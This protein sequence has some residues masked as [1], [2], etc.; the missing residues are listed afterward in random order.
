MLEL[1]LGAG[2]KGLRTL[3]TGRS[4]W[5]RR[6]PVKIGPSKAAKS[7][8]HIEMLKHNVDPTSFGDREGGVVMPLSVVHL[9]MLMGGA[10]SAPYWQGVAEASNPIYGYGSALTPYDHMP[11]IPDEFEVQGGSLPRRELKNLVNS[12]PTAM[13]QGSLNVGLIALLQKHGGNP[14]VILAADVAGAVGGLWCNLLSRTVSFGSFTTLGATTGLVHLYEDVPDEIVPR[15]LL[16]PGGGKL[17]DKELLERIEII[18]GAGELAKYAALGALDSTQKFIDAYAL[19]VPLYDLSGITPAKV[20]FKPKALESGVQV[21]DDRIVETILHVA[22]TR[23][24]VVL[25]KEAV[26]ES[27]DK[28][29][30]VVTKDGSASEAADTSAKLGDA[31]QTAAIQTFQE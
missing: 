2:H 31:L 4:T 29:K 11:R 30:K 28:G 3:N 19:S 1:V 21:R 13:Q 5:A 9:G 7:L 8:V 16:V 12:V 27:L 23:H 20:F 14:H 6:V 22:R 15:G 10:A 25:K 26:E 24:Q 17:T 18:G